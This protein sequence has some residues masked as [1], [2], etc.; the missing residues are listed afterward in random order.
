MTVTVTVDEPVVWVFGYGSLVWRPAMAYRARR[1]ARLEG[2]ARRFWQA[3]TD[4]RG[5]P[6]APGRV[7]TLLEADAALWGVAYAIAEADWPAVEPVL[8]HREQQG[9]ARLTV[10]AQLAGADRAGPIVETVDALLY[11]MT[12]VN[13]YFV[14][15]EPLAATAAVVRDAH[16][17]SGANLDYVVEL[18]RALAALDARDPEVDALIDALAAP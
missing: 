15:P 10:R 4:H 5:T 9:Y 3:S 6:E 7:L 14:G 17:P 8:E 1:A 16:G 2:W 13:P 18:G 11:V 12:P